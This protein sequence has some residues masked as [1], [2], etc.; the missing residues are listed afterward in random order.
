[1]FGSYLLSCTDKKILDNSP[2]KGATAHIRNEMDINEII[3]ED[4][5]IAPNHRDLK[6]KTTP[7][8]LWEELEEY[9]EP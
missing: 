8:P 4:R 6:D 5:P 9:Y 7:V 3:S 2:C 1:M